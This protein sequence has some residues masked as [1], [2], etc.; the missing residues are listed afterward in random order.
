[1]TNDSKKSYADFSFA[2]F[3]K[4]SYNLDKKNATNICNIIVVENKNFHYFNIFFSF[5]LYHFNIIS[6]IID[7]VKNTTTTF[8]VIGIGIKCIAINSRG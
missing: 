3:L 7:S 2:T 6:N 5:P 1:M 8:I 4:F